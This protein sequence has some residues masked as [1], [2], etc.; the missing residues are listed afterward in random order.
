MN[1]EMADDEQYYFHS[2][3]HST[4]FKSLDKGN[5]WSSLN[6]FSHHLQMLWW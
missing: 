3:N 2:L 4:Y 5:K 1:I 6:I